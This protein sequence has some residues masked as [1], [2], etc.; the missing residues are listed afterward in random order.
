[1][2]ELLLYISL[3]SV[4]LILTSSFFGVLLKARVKNQVM[5][6]VG[7]QGMQIVQVINQTIRNAEAI[8]SPIQGIT[9]S[10]LTLDILNVSDDPTVFNLN[11]EKIYITEG[12]GSAISLSSDNI[13]ASD[14]SFSNYSRDNTAGIIT[15]QFT[16]SYDNQSTRNEYDFSKIFYGS[17][18]LY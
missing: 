3:S 2:L 6:E 18:T 14:L 9:A 4:I 7:Q 17:A 15:F 1:M 13:I 10:S 12:A 16:L 8:T 11:N 5:A